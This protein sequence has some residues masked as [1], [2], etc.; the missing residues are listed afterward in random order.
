MWEGL[1]VEK[2]HEAYHSD[3]IIYRLIAVYA[4]LDDLQ[5]LSVI[6]LS[7]TALAGFWHPAVSTPI[8]RFSE[9]SLTKTNPIPRFAPVTRTEYDAIVLISLNCNNRVYNQ[10]KEI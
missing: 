3:G 7:S 5:S 9:N 1:K 10:R 8:P 2:N 6:E 4:E